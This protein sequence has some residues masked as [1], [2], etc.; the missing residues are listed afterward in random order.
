[1]VKSTAAQ[2]AVSNK[3]GSPLPLL[4]NLRLQRA[5]VHFPEMLRAQP[6]DVQCMYQNN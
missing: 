1:M 3:T 6:A 5:E 4:L 2:V